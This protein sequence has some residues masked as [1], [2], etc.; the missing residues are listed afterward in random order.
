MISESWLQTFVAL[1]VGSGISWAVSYRYFKRAG[2][3]LRAEAA[4]LRKLTESALQVLTDPKGKYELVFDNA[5][6]VTGLKVQLGGAAFLAIPGP[7][8]GAP[9]LSTKPPSQ[10]GG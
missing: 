5:G 6:M 4:K 7:V 10:S 9:S 1:L 3:E 8:L 2:D